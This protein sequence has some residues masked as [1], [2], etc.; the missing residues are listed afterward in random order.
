MEY[1]IKK[2]SELAGVSA[3]TL[4]YYDEIGLL[5][6]C[7][8]NSSGYRIYGKN[9]VDL[10]QQI[11]FYKSLDMKLE[12]IQNIVLNQEFDINKALIKHH[13]Q[14]ISKR[15]QIDQLILTVEKTIQHK[16]GEIDMSD[17]EKFEA[18][19]KAKLEE[20]EVKYGEE[21]RTKYGANTIEESNKKWMNMT[22]EDLNNMQ[23]I[24]KEMFE[25]L[26]EV[27]KIKDLDSDLAKKVYEKHKEWLCFSWTSY[28]PQAHVGLA[29]MYV[30]DERFAKYYNDRAGLEATKTLHDIIVKY[31]K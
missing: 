22:E 5:K 26:K 6:P 7:R 1:T 27:I 2:L 17:R 3:R 10:L 13:Q 28:S 21:I 29:Q 30:Y 23:E 16:K 24:E 14:L 25:A 20:N 8:V 9:E 19:K 4:R 18:F 31:A 11:L 15:D 12:D